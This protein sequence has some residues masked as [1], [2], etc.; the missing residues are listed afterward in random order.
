MVTD[1]FGAVPGVQS[2]VKPANG[3]YR[4]AWT[5]DSTAPS[6]AYSS[7]RRLLRC[8]VVSRSLLAS[9]TR[10]TIMS[11]TISTNVIAS[12]STAPLSSRRDLEAG[13][14]IGYRARVVRVADCDLHLITHVGRRGRSNG[15][16]LK[17]VRV[18]VQPA[19]WAAR[20][21]V[22]GKVVPGL[23]LRD[24]NRVAAAGSVSGWRG[25]LAVHTV[26]VV[27]QHLR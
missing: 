24:R 9:S 25:P 12:S 8:D 14:R 17:A 5:A 26:S 16:Q 1:R 7:D 10:P 4:T 6:P 27:G 19:R 23:D 11:E 20:V 13:I 2:P 22:T 15:E 3:L 21:P 18:V